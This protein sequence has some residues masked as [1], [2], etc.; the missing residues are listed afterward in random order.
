[1]SRSTLKR[2]D[3]TQA[4]CRK[5]GLNRSDSHQLLGQL[6]DRIAEALIAGEMVKIKNFGVFEVRDKAA[7]PGR[8]PRTGDPYMI[9]AHRS[10]HFRPSGTVRERV[11]AAPGPDD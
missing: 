2:E 6:L 5:T 7:R 10:L 3:L 1:M 11:A 8:N 9:T 4:V